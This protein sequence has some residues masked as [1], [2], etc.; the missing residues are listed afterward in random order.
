M[1]FLLFAAYIATSNLITQQDCDHAARMAKFAIKVMQLADETLVDEDDPCKGTP[2]N[3]LRSWDQGGAERCW[4]LVE[5]GGPFESIS[6]NTNHRFD[7]I[8]CR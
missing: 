8:L 4:R 3:T 6:L 2:F 7:G 1:P 5:E